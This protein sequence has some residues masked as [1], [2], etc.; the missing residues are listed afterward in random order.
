MTAALTPEQI[1]PVAYQFAIRQ[2]TEDGWAITGWAYCDLHD[3]RA[4]MIPK[5]ALYDE[6]TVKTLQSRIEAL[7]AE[8]AALRDSECDKILAMSE[9]QINALTRMQGSNPEDIA[10]L[11]RMTARAALKDVEIARLRAELAACKRNAERHRFLDVTC[12]QC[13]RNFG[14]G[15]FGFS[16]CEDHTGESYNLGIDA[17]AKWLDKRADDYDSEHGSTDPDTGT[18]EYPGDGLDYINELR[19]NADSIRELKRAAIDAAMAAGE[20]K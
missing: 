17:A 5:R 18:R 9:T 13:G 15:N 1:K 3:Y 19:E 2:E 11:G 20:P 8:L 14:P 16:R 4:L 12:S 6:A 10:Q 7:E